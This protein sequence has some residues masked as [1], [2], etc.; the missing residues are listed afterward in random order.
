MQLHQFIE[1]AKGT[2][3]IVEHLIPFSQKC[4]VAGAPGSLKSWFL[5]ALALS[6]ASGR[7]FLG[8]FSVSRHGPV[9]YIDQDSPEG[10]FV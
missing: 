9:L 7:D 3:W 2:E 5:Q 10:E 4:L 8:H 6:V 1:Q